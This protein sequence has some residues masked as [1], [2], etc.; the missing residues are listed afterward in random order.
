MAEARTDGGQVLVV[1]LSLDMTLRL[2]DTSRRMNTHQYAEYSCTAM[3]ASAYKAHAAHLVL[4]LSQTH[5]WEPMPIS[6]YMSPQ[7]RDGQ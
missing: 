5:T 4:I 3:A 2:W 6:I 1:W 7:T